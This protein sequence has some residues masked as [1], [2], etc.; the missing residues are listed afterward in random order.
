[1]KKLVEA[2][3]AQ[4]EVKPKLPPYVAP[5]AP[6]NTFALKPQPR[7]LEGLRAQRMS[8]RSTVRHG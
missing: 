7:T 5:E 8:P 6:T 2:L 1:M 3:V 4:A